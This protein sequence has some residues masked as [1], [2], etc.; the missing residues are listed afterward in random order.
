MRCIEADVDGLIN[1]DEKTKH[2]FQQ[3]S[4]HHGIYA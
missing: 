2:H 1:K 4:D 3:M